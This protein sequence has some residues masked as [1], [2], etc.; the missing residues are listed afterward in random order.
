MDNED[1]AIKCDILSQKVDDVEKAM[2]E[3]KPQ[4]FLCYEW[5]PWLHK[6]YRW[7]RAVFKHCP[8]WTPMEADGGEWADPGADAGSQGAMV[9]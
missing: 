3:L 6:L 8:G 9:V 4:V 1:L 7:L 2:A 5:V